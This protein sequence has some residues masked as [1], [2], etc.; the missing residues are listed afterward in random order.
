MRSLRKDGGLIL[1][2]ERNRAN[3]GS[4]TGVRSG[5]KAALLVSRL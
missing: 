3:D 1:E 4:H 5:V 2:F